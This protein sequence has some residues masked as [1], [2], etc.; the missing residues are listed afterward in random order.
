V[1]GTYTLSGYW[2]VLDSLT[3]AD[4]FDIVTNG[5]EM[6]GY[7]RQSASGTHTLDTSFSGFSFKNI[8]LDGGQ[9]IYFLAGDPGVTGFSTASPVGLSVQVAAVPEPGT[10]MLLGAGAGALFL[11]RRRRKTA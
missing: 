9:T 6:A 1:T 10:F 4:T 2:E 7:T 5:A 11:I 8:H 3:S